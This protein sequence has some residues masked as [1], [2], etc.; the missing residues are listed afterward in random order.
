MSVPGSRTLSVICP[1]LVAATVFV[2]FL[3]TLENDFVRFDDEKNFLTNSRWRGFTAESL[4]WMW[5]Q[6]HLGHYHP[7][8]WMSLALDDAI[9]GPEEGEA[10][11]PNPDAFHFTNNL[12]H[13]WNAAAVCLLAVAL[14]RRTP[15]KIAEID[16]RCLWLGAALAAVL[17]GVHPQRVESVA[18]ATERRDVLS[19]AFLIPAVITYLR[20][21]DRTSRRWLWY[22]ATLALTLLSLLSKAWGITF[23]AILLILDVWPL[24]RIGFGRDFRWNDWQRSVVEKIPFGVASLVFAAFAADAQ[25]VEGAWISFDNY[26]LTERLAN[27][28]LALC[29]YVLKTLVPTGLHAAVMQPTGASF[30]QWPYWACGGAVASM[31]VLAV[32][33]RKRRPAVSVTALATLVL[34]SPVLGLS[35]S[36]FQLAADRYT[37]LAII[38]FVVIAAGCLAWLLQRSVPTRV[39]ASVGA[40]AIG[41]A[42]ITLTLNQIPIWENE[43][44]LWS[45]A[46]AVEP[47]NTFANF[48]LGVEYSK[49]RQL[50]DAVEYLRVALESA[51]AGNFEQFEQLSADEIREITAYQSKRAAE[52]R[53]AASL[54]SIEENPNDPEPV[55]DL[56]ALVRRQNISVLEH[57]ENAVRRMPENGQMRTA[58]GV[59]Q[60]RVGKFEEALA[61]FKKAEQLGGTGE[62]FYLFR[63]EALTSLGRFDAAIATFRQALE[64]DPKSTTALTQLGRVL[65]AA[66]RSRDAL[67]FL[68]RA[69]ELDPSDA[70]AR[71]ILALVLIDT[72]QLRAAVNQLQKTIETAGNSD[73]GR[74]AAAK[75]QELSL[76]MR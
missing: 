1:L 12:L 21:C 63:G 36:G 71:F 2:V 44:T 41:A 73:I 70:P 69:V 58:L 14:I 17:Y 24:R 45:R 18:W 25:E 15:E 28:S 57:V 47:K 59:E 68:T 10:Q 6:P 37:Y 52:A 39:V 42:Y 31:G 49:R 76:R 66:K 19:A 56:V 51:K 60:V 46:V 3:P 50:D 26:P 20:Y 38:P 30:L 54:K 27:A 65:Y 75:L 35:Q 40:V 67:P 8:T 13:A 34:L 16:G 62:D 48:A 74:R 7:L 32:W 72:G 64:L 11:R 61:T 23:P 5:S 33:L 9:W 22:A 29:W 43:I 4:G 53:L 55:L